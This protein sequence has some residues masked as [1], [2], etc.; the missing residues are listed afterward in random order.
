M[1]VTF[2][3]KKHLPLKT[4]T[5]I[6][7]TLLRVSAIYNAN[8]GLSAMGLIVAYYSYNWGDGVVRWDLLWLIIVI[9]G[10]MG[11]MGLLVAYCSYNWG[12]GYD[13]TCG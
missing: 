9:I 11:T 6:I 13:G 7:I 1:W 3:G 2:L 4:G 5:C 8:V 12:N 10:V